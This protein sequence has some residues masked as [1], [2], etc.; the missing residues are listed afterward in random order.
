MDYR[1]TKQ[2]KWLNLKAPISLASNLI[3]YGD[4]M[5]EQP[6]Q[7]KYWDIESTQDDYCE[8]QLAGLRK[9]AVIE[10]IDAALARS[11]VR[12][13]RILEIGGG[14]QFVSRHL[15][16]RFPEAEVVCS[17]ISDVRIATF[18]RYYKTTP[19]NLKTIGGID[20]RSLPFDNEEFDLILGDAMLHHIDFLKPA[21]FEI[22]RCLAP[23]GTA[24]FVREPIIGLL[25]VWL[26]RLFQLIGRDRKHIE[27]NYFEYK[28][29][30]SQW[31]Y[32]FMMAGFKVRTLKLWRNQ[33]FLWRLRALFPHFSPCYIGFILSG[34]TNIKNLILQS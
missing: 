32:E 13:R 15:C 26:Y 12:P 20:A 11:A 7:K 14:S 4:E 27:I 6:E 18:N 23:S 33:G 24:I 29:M 28:R 2:P 25:G 9:I 5:I 8:K 19:S 22:H 3:N 16:H 31:Q 34:K 30:L 10:M 1:E 17:D 21:L